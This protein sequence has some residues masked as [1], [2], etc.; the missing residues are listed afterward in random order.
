VTGDV[1]LPCGAQELKRQIGMGNILS[2][3]G[4]RVIVRETGITLPCGSGYSVTVDLAAGD[5]YTARRLFKRAGRTW[6]HGEQTDVYCDQVGEV[7]YRAGMFRDEWEGQ[8]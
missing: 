3:S 7:A 6:Q 5:T 2:I 4:G 1:F 8:R